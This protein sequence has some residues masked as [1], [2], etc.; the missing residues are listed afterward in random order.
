MTKN[1]TKRTIAVVLSIL[2]ASGVVTAN[3]S[4]G[5]VVVD[6]AIV[7]S[8]ET[9][10]DYEYT[11]LEDGTVEISKYIGSDEVLVIP[12]EIDG[13]KVSAIGWYAFRDCSSITSVTI[14]DSVTSIGFMAYY[15]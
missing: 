3:S 10:G 15:G 13:Y 2:C 11:F 9:Y 8:A 12:S 5:G 6:T 4:L 1:I 7:A 14:P